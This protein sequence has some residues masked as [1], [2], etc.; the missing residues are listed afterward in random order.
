[1]IGLENYLQTWE[2]ALL[3]VSHQR[4]FLNAVVTD[5][6][7][8][9]SKKLEYYKGNYDAFEQA[10]YERLTLQQRKHD[11]QVKQKKHI[12][13]FIDRFRYN[14]KRASLVQSRIKT[15]EK[16][17]VVEEVL[18]DPTLILQFPDPD[19]VSLPHLQFKDVSFGY[20]PENILFRDLN[21]GIDMDSRVALVG[22][23]GVGKSTLM[24]LLSGELQPSTGQVVR[25]PKLRFARFSQFFVETLSFDLSPLEH[26]L[27]V[28]PGVTPQLARTHLGAFGL[29]GDIALRT[30]N[31]LSGG[32]KSRLVF[33]ILAWKKPHILL[34]DEPT[35]DGKKKKKNF[36]KLN[37][38]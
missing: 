26:F 34:L 1:M 7:H 13:A 17:D 2:G 21:I 36:F 27:K 12:Q 19:P 15:L 18:N 11:A 33:A 14:A 5:I 24:H 9:H 23:N 22:A 8:L 38:M 4:E 25:N 37:F 6:I 20:T 35:Y 32:Q 16:M 30:I 31:T 10:R 29:S 3:I 28:Y